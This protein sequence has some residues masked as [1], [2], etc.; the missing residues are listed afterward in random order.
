MEWL[1]AALGAT[2]STGT[3]IA[4]AIANKRSQQR[5]YEYN[6]ALMREQYQLE[7]E[8]QDYQN[9]YNSPSEQRKRLEAAGYNPNQ[10]LESYQSADASAPD[11]IPMQG[12][13]YSASM[14]QIGN[15]VNSFFS[16]ASQQQQLRYQKLKNDEQQIRNNLL[17]EQAPILSDNFYTDL[18]SSRSE[19]YSKLMQSGL[20]KDVA[21]KI[22]FVDSDYHY[23]G[24]H[25]PLS[26]LYL[27]DLRGDTAWYSDNDDG[28][29]YKE[30]KVWDH[31]PFR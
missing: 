12:L 8:Q 14:N 24:H 4:G 7:R 13:D 6:R 16:V 19:L 11:P 17:T 29:D 5:A 9:F 21:R 18:F 15:S 23:I 1:G 3:G 27:K 20:S 2:V 22:A 26:R 25:E 30:H 10:G 31:V 28:S